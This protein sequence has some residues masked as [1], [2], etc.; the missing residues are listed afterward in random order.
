M[1]NVQDQLHLRPIDYDMNLQDIL[2]PIHAL[3]MWAFD[4][5]AAVNDMGNNILIILISILMLYWI[6]QL[7][8]V[9]K[10]EVPNR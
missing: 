4:M 1:L 6:G 10:D 8:K 7:V 2:D 5:L 3:F 9:N